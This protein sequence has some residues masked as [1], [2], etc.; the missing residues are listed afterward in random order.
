ML[1]DILDYRDRTRWERRQALDQM[2]ADAED[3]G[4][5]EVTATPKRTTLLRLAEAEAYRPLWLSEI[6]AEGPPRRRRSRA[7]QR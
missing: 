4:L 1:R 6:L 7:R 3:D 5:Y 2:A